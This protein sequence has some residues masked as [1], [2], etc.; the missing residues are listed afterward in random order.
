MA[1]ALS[2]SLFL[3]AA[4]AAPPRLY[5]ADYIHTH[6]HSG[7]GRERQRVRAPTA[8]LYVNVLYMSIHAR[9]YCFNIQPDYAARLY[10]W[11]VYRNEQDVAA[12]VQQMH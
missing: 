12:L 7:R 9:I 2:L 3:S 6:Q 5:A 1:D 4:A 8:E 10:Y 11:R